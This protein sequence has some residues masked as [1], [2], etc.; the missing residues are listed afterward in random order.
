MRN[1]RAIASGTP[2]FPVEDGKYPTSDVPGEVASETQPL[3]TLPAPFARQFL[4]EDMLSN[5][6]PEIHEWA[7]GKFR[8]FRSAGQFVPLTVGKETVVF[9]GFDGGAEWGGQAF[10]PETG[11]ARLGLGVATTGEPALLLLD[12]GGIDR[13][14]MSLRPDGKPG[15]AFADDKGKTVAGYPQPAPSN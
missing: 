2:L 14:E 13:A 8:E 11:L 15:V 10:D 9:P 12:K 7:L 6:T 4:T 1:Q 3:P 5:R